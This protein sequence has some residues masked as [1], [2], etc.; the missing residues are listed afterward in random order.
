MFGHSFQWVIFHPLS[1]TTKSKI[2]KDCE[3]SENG[4]FRFKT[5]W[6]TKWRYLIEQ[7]DGASTQRRS[8]KVIWLQQN[9]SSFC[10]NI[11]EPLISTQ[12][13]PFSGSCLDMFVVLINKSSIVGTYH[14]ESRGL[15]RGWNIYLCKFKHFAAKKCWSSGTKK[16]IENNRILSF[17]VLYGFQTPRA[18][19]H[20]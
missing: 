10:K 11:H 18:C 19:T 13:E 9:I 20:I 5:P 16:K 8:V 7:I 12:L 2:L 3:T 4:I 14:Q 6:L 1:L 15:D 17:Y